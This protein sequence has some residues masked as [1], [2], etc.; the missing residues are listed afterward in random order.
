MC[1]FK[2]TSPI[3]VLA[4]VQNRSGENPPLPWATAARRDFRP[5]C[6]DVDYAVHDDWR[7][8]IDPTLI[9]LTTPATMLLQK[10]ELDYL[11]QCGCN[12]GDNESLDT[13]SVWTQYKKIG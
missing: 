13:A 5:C 12:V 9:I 4:L 11:S 2:A 1:G 3:L 6:T 7:R 10:W 8:K